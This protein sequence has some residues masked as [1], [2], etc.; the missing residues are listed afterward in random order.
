MSGD[1]CHKLTRNNDLRNTVLSLSI[2][3]LTNGLLNTSSFKN[4]ALWILPALQK[5]NN[6]L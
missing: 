3:L 6:F 5:K 1:F 2:V 4:T